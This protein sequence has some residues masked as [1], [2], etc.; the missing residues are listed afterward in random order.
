[1]TYIIET[2]SHGNVE[3]GFFSVFGHMTR[4]GKY[5]WVTKHFCNMTSV[6]ANNPDAHVLQVPTYP[7]EKFWTKCEDYIC[8]RDEIYCD[9]FSGNGATNDTLL[10]RLQ[11]LEQEPQLT[12]E[13]DVR[14]E[15]CALDVIVDK[16]EKRIR[17]G[18]YV[19]EA[20]HF[21]DLAIYV[22]Q[23]GIFGTLPGVRFDYADYLM[24][25][26]RLSRRL[27]FKDIQRE[28]ARGLN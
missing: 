6:I 1:M 20:F 3:A 28:M 14:G 2:V 22:A 21:S 19:V 10:K 26:I 17:I 15:T 27:F 24:D 7:V 8:A 9:H 4:I 13:L 23:G 5:A 16:K 25:S 12:D 11:V 18:E